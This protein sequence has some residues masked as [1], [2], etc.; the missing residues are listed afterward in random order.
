MKVG[1]MIYHRGDDIEGRGCCWSGGGAVRF[2]VSK[3]IN[4]LATE[5]PIWRGFPEKP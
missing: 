2:Q 1:Y 4:S 3:N 5:S